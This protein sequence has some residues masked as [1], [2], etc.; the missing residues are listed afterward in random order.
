MSFIRDVK[1]EALLHKKHM[2][3]PCSFKRK[4]R[5]FSVESLQFAYVLF[6]GGNP[7]FSEHGEVRFVFSEK[8]GSVGFVQ[9]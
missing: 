9:A 8:F 6:F 5:I 3:E 1:L 4:M 2:S 7:T